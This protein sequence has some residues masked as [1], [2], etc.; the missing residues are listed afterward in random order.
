MLTPKKSVP[1]GKAFARNEVK[2]PRTSERFYRK[3]DF[4]LRA[5]RISGP[6]F[7]SLRL[8]RLR[9]QQSPAPPSAP[10]ADTISAGP[11]VQSRGQVREEFS[12]PL[13]APRE[14]ALALLAPARSNALGRVPQFGW[15]LPGY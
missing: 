11:G 8:R 6:K 10:A 5:S 12:L 7:Q 3:Q 13:L 15:A 4:E 2:L 1:Q 14:L 9:R